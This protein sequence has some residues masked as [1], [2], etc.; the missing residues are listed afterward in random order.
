MNR[1]TFLA[2]SVAGISAV[3]AGCT[4]RAGLQGE[5][6]RTDDVT[7]EVDPGTT[8]RVDNRNGPVIVEG[9]DGDAVEVAIE[10]TAPSSDALDEVSVN[11]DETDDE[12]RVETDYEDRT[13]FEWL[14]EWDRPSVAFT[15]RCPD[16]VPVGRVRTRN[17]SV[18]VTDVGGDP[19]IRSSNGRVTAQNV[20]GTV[21]LSTSNGRVTAR[22]VAGLAG[23]ST[24]N[25]AI[26]VD[27]PSIDGS[28]TIETSNG[29]IDAA[30]ASDLDATVSAST[31][32]GS[33][34]IHDLDLSSV[35]TGRTDV[36]GTLGEG[37]HDLSIET[38][39]GSIG[40]RPL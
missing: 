8:L 6:R 10:I 39:N 1:R 22:N 23:A 30:I 11:V 20:D 37:T 26:D 31:T 32:N 36:E 2:G 19:E 38:T 24:S 27:V 17:G 21:S 9:H 29:A 5:A 16:D 34:D 28:V 12:L 4:S 18:E 35:G 3:L 25:G 40:L 33:V 15:I 7:A 13:G 14:F